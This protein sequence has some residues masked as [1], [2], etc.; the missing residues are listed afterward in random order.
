MRSSSLRHVKRVVSELLAHCRTRTMTRQQEA[1]RRQCQDVP[2][3]RFQ[4]GVIE[5]SRVRTSDRSGE[6]RIAHERHRTPG[7]LDTITNP[8]GR[9]TGGRKTPDRQL[10][11]SNGPSMLW[12]DKLFLRR[13]PM[14]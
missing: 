10:T 13:L 5:L 11:D 2:T 3:D 12:C 4:V 1:I 7:H 8:T 9:M 6:E 14:E